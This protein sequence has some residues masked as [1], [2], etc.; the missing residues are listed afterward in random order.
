MH[1][2]EQCLAQFNKEQRKRII[3]TSILTVL[4]LLVVLGVSWNLRRTGI[5]MANGAFCGREEHWHTED[6][7]SESVLI[8]DYSDSVNSGTD[9]M[10]PTEELVCTEAEHTHGASCYAEEMALICTAGHE[11]SDGCYTQESILNCEETH[12]HG[13]DCYSITPMLTCTQGHE[14]TDVCYKTHTVLNCPIAEH[15]H[16][17]GCYAVYDPAETAEPTHIHTDDCYKTEYLCGYEAHIHDLTCYSDAT[18]DIE[19]AYVW[20]ASLPKQLTEQWAENLVMVAQSQ[21]GCAESTQNYILAEDGVTKQGITRYGQWYGNPYGDWS[22]MFLT[23]C[24]RYAEIPQEAFPWN[25]GVYNMM[26]LAE[27]AGIFCAPDAE[28]GTAGNVLFLDTDDNGNA[29][30]A[31][32]VTG[33][34]DSDMIAIGGDWNDAV[35]E[36]VIPADDEMILGYIH[37]D[38]LQTSYE[39][40]HT[41]EPA[42]QTEPSEDEELTEDSTPIVL[43]AVFLDQLTGE[44]VEIDDSAELPDSTTV[45]I[46]AQLTDIEGSMYDWQWQVSTDGNESWTDIAGA[47]ALTYEF[48]ATEENVTCYYRLQGQKRAPMRRMLLTAAPASI[49]DGFITS[50]GI[51]PLSIG[52]NNNVYTVDVYALPI[53]ASGKRIT[54]INPTKITTVSINSTTKKQVST[55]FTGISGTYQSAYFGSA[56]SVSVDNIASIWRY[57]SGSSYYLAYAQ[58]NGTQNQR[59]KNSAD[60]SISLYLRYIPNYTVSFASD[61]FKTLKETVS[62]GSY[63]TLTE[64]ADWSREGYSLVGWSAG[65]GTQTIYSYEELMKLPVTK[66]VTYTAQ[67]KSL[68]TLSFDLGEYAS[69]LY[70]I[71][72]MQLIYGSAVQTLPVPQWRNSTASMAF[73]GWY[74]NTD[75]TVPVDSDTVFYENTILHAKWIPTDEGYFVYFMD[76][77]REGQEPLVLT[78]YSV[79]EGRKAAPF[80]PGNA[81]SGTQWDGKWYLKDGTVYSFA[82]P[83]S[84]MTD[85]LEGAN[86]RDLYLHPGTQDICRAIFVTYGTRIDPVTI[87]VGGTVDLSKYIPQRVGYVFAGWTLKDGT[88]VSGVQTL[89]ETTT[90]Y[91]AWNSDY[92]PF[93]A[94]LRIENANDT[95]MTQSDILGTWYA[96]AGSRIR[97]NSTYTGTG[98]NRV[99]THKVVCVLNGVEY[100]VYSNVGLTQQATLNDAYA[101]YFIYNNT[102]TKWTDEINWDD[103]YTGGEVPYSTRPISSAGDTIINFD[104]MRVRNDIVFTIPNSSAYIDIFRLYRDGLITG[105]VTYTGTAPTTTGKNVSASGVS[106]TD[107]KWSYTAATTTRGNNL[108]TLHDMK[109][110]QR[111]YEVYPVGGSWLTVRSSDF[112]WYECG[113]GELFS[114]RREDLSSDFFAGS[115]RKVAPYSLTGV[116]ENQSR[117]ALMYAI[118][119]LNG[120]TPDFTINGV[121][122]KVQPQLCEVVNHTG[123]FSTKDLLGCKPG[124]RQE[125]TGL[126]TSTAKIGNTSVKTLFGTTYWSYY[127]R[128]DGVDK[129]SDISKAFIF[130]YDR[131]YMGIEFDFDYDVDGD[132]TN[133]T[134]KYAN[135][136]Y[137]VKI[138]EY[139]FGMPGFEHHPLLQRADYAFAGWMDSNGFV[140]EAESWD[141]LVASGDSEDS[142][143]IFVA[144]WEKI[145]NNIVEYYED[146]SAAEPFAMHYFDDGDFVQYPSMTVYPDGWVWQEY[147][148]GVYQRFDWDVPMYG[149]YGVKEIRRINGEDREVN[150][151]RIYG[152]WDESH[153]S[154]IYDPN[155]AQGGIPGTAPV[156]SNEY[157]IWQSEVPVAPKG[158]T[159]N[160]DPDMVFVGWLL[161][162]NGIVYQPGDHVPVH[163]PRTM[164]FT[165]QWAK[166]EDVVHLRYDPNGAAP[167]GRYPNDD[168]FA[169]K[170]H[171]SALVWDNTGEDGSV[172]YLRPGYRFTGWNTAPDGS[173]TAY[174]PN[175][176]LVLTEPLTTLYAQWESYIHTLSLY[177]V[178]SESEAA[179]RGAEFALYKST[180]GIFVLAADTLTTGTDGHIVISNL[181]TGILYKLVEEKTPDGYTIITKEIFFRIVPGTSGVSF[182]F[183]DADGNV[184]SSPNGV[185]GEYNTSSRVLTLTVRN[186]RGYELPSTG[187]IGIPIYIL[188]GLILISAPLVYGFRLRRIYGRRLK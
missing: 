163:W 120:E 33:A 29:D 50:G 9:D 65:S 181:E 170:K 60:N 145:S 72:P 86:N 6:C 47:T 122:Y 187:G 177:K 107:V 113:S 183:C 158:T 127:D 84:D 43:T 67:W 175:D 3:T 137:G 10:Q 27:A 103:I 85:Y 121:G 18:A 114:S 53:D 185:T 139:Q 80:T 133:E 69:Q 105:S 160:A 83:V 8:C 169:Y 87:P 159:A 39:K 13:D 1:I 123:S 42:E 138:A 36:V 78:T 140:M 23:F 96:K 112:H 20:E 154:V 63:P 172:Y 15:V 44:A 111:I 98:T 124:T 64:P 186:L 37:V 14:H 131:L 151:I 135:I 31:L 134:V 32:I 168:G 149:E 100:P 82:I 94:I 89:N 165:A 49:D 66:D 35:A 155:P 52:K 153:T 99:G 130:Y 142:A 75:M 58:T 119:C 157:T 62:Y 25:A 92:V 11:H 95:G 73:G 71:E 88:H 51:M 38:K 129:L 117:L 174:S 93:E 126:S 109:Y 152:I 171:A 2:I 12:D 57:R 101:T 34:R 166:K 104:Y 118:E 68:I 179:L 178:D 21:I 188:C 162:R 48:A 54:G 182:V 144:K 46:T 173:G 91:A 143:M 180:D 45:R 161:N 184:I 97:V 115:G 61:G 147:G 90:Y 56:T 125:Y 150:V 128:Y 16:T 136:P 106:G 141:S 108:Y 40:K 19:S 77:E 26:R 76:F 7:A 164:I 4:S 22:A 41:A 74:L 28:M 116:F 70:P 146:L 167:E 148:E 156:D 30:K 55:L 59:Y 5:T 110:G 102:G 132:G 81:P 79:A 24:L 176:I 17:D